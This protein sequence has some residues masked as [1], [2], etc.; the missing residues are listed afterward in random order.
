VRDALH[1]LRVALHHRQQPLLGLFCHS[2]KQGSLAKVFLLHSLK[3]GSLA[4]VFLLH[5]LK[6]RV[7]RKSLSAS[8]PQ[9]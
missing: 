5:S 2:L 3:Q 7:T 4:K 6:H 9:T 1:V 8:Q